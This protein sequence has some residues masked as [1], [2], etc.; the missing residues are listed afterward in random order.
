VPP[1]CVT[2]EIAANE[3]C[4]VRTKRAFKPVSFVGSFRSVPQS[5]AIST[6]LA[7]FQT[8]AGEFA[9]ENGPELAWAP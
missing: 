4:V 6:V 9:R 5:V 3:I 8:A 7:A 1:I 2:R